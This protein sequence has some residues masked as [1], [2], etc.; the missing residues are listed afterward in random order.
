VSIRWFLAGFAV[1]IGLS[2]SSIGAAQADP[3]TPAP[4]PTTTS[5]DDELVDM[6]LEAIQHGGAAPTTTPVPAP[7]R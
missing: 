6:V 7:P 5:T 1:L 2:V 3:A 4:G